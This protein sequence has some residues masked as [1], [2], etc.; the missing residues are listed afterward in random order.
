MEGCLLPASFESVFFLAVRAYTKRKRFA[1]ELCVC[2]SAHAMHILARSSAI[3][4][5]VHIHYFSPPPWTRKVG[6][7]CVSRWF[8]GR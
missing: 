8:H 1:M 6:G 5:V 4:V 2:M 3:S 7:G